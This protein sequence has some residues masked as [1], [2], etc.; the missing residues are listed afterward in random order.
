MA[1]DGV[2]GQVRTAASDILQATVQIVTRESRW[3]TS[4]V[5]AVLNLSTRVCGARVT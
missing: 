1:G 5:V 3:L 2:T 4:P